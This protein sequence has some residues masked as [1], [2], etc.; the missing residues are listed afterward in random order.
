LNKKLTSAIGLL[1]AFAFILGGCQSAVTPNAPTE[2]TEDAPIVAAPISEGK[3]E[4]V[5]LN[6]LGEIEPRYD[7]PL[8]E[9]SA[10]TDILY[11]QGTRTL[12]LG[13]SWYT[14]PLDGE[15][16]IALGQMLKEKWEADSASATNSQIPAGLTVR[17]VQTPT[18]NAG[19]HPWN[20]KTDAT[21]DG[22]ADNA[23]AM[24]VGVGD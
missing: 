5:F 11:A 24:I 10:V 3:N 16:A 19:L 12:R 8:A 7:V 6:P 22:W 18:I 23:D 1:L 20:N 4:Y 13:V 2:P 15:P 21:Y 9:R 17:L 14:K